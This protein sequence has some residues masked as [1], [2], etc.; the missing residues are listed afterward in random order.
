MPTFHI[1]IDLLTKVF[2]HDRQF[3]KALF[4]IFIGLELSQEVR[5]KLQGVV[6][7]IADEEC[8]VNEVVGVR[9]VVKVRKEHW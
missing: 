4:R 2:L 6:L 5:E 7:R 9:Q 8:E 1:L 3:P